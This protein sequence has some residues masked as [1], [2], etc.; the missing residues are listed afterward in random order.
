M[1]RDTQGAHDLFF[2][3]R[4]QQKAR[5]RCGSSGRSFEEG[6]E[7]V[8]TERS[9]LGLCY[10]LRVIGTTSI[11]P[12]PA[13]SVFCDLSFHTGQRDG[14]ASPGGSEGAN[15]HPSKRRLRREHGCRRFYCLPLGPLGVLWP[16]NGNTSIHTRS[17]LN[18]SP[19]DTNPTP[20]TREKKRC[21]RLEKGAERTRVWTPQDLRALTVAVREPVEPVA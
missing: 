8:G 17:P 21:E 4:T 9:R 18:P 5:L 3:F 11:D 12:S 16:P 1:R 14:L 2:Y 15:L 19:G 6:T 13:A 7:Q 10:Y 20:P